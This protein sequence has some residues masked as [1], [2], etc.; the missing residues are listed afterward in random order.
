MSIGIRVENLPGDAR[1][2][3]LVDLLSGYSDVRVVRLVRSGVGFTASSRGLVV[4]GDRKDAARAVRALNGRYCR[5]RL[6]QVESV[7]VDS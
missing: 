7:Q 4:L 6:L 1:E 3:T 2:Q 5:G